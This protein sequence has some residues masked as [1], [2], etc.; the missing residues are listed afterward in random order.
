[1]GHRRFLAYNHPYRSKEA[2]FDGNKEHR[3]SPKILTGR[4]V[5]C[6]IKNVSNNWGKIGK[7]RKMKKSDS[8]W[9]WKKKSIFFELPY[10]EVSH[11]KLF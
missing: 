2:W 7:K 3:P 5:M 11:F 8:N 6:S 4:E 9:P 1:M 10:W